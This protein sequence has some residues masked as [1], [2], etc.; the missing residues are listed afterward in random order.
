MQ[1]IHSLTSDNYPELMDLVTQFDSGA[2]T[3]R[4]FQRRVRELPT[5]SLLIVS[6]ILMPEAETQ[7]LASHAGVNS[8]ASSS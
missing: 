4:E 6:R 5:E 8:S 2:L 1:K 3:R 7:V